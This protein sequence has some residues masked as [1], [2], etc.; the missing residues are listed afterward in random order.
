MPRWLFWTLMTLLSWGIWGVLS[1]V[2]AQTPLHSQAMLTV[3]L[4]PIIAVLRGIIRPAPHGN[5]RRGIVLAFGSGIAS[6][7]G[8]VAFF[9]ALEG[10]KA[11]TIVPLTALSPAVTVLLAVP[12]LKERVTPLQWCGM[13]LSVAAIYLFNAEGPPREFNPWMMAALGAI[14]LWGVTL[15]MQKVSTQHIS[16]EE[17]AFWFLI[18]FLPVAGA[19]LLYDPLP[20]GISARTWALAAAIGFTLAFGNLTI[21]L[22]FASGGKA[23]IIAPL[24]GLYPLVS[25][26]IAMAALGE[27]PEG[28]ERLGIALALVAVVCLS[29]SAE[30]APAAGDA[31]QGD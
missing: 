20:S 19:I 25:I 21:L 12:L 15:L 1:E 6:S 18:A 9:A 10:A 22:A 27:R 14:F 31:S 7:L 24:S 13:L 3:G 8:N 16:A 28:R 4:L 17:S 5:R 30:P 2:I 11:A 29:S 26:A 23:A